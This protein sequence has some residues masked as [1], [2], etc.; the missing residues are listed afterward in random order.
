[1]ILTCSKG[2]SWKI[3]MQSRK[4][5]NGCRQCKDESRVENARR[6]FEEQA[7]QQEEQEQQQRRLLD[8]HTVD[9]HEIHVSV[10][11]TPE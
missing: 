3:G 9:Y 1:M 5:K 2:H 8:S 4:A 6:Q 11:H 7:R 10:D